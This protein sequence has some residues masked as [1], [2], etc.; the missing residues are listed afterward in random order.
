MMEQNIKT[1]HLYLKEKFK[2]KL[3]LIMTILISAT[4]LISFII[5]IYNF[6][7]ST[8]YKNS[9]EI[10]KA[11]KESL[12]E[13]GLSTELEF[14]EQEWFYYFCNTCSFLTIIV[15]LINSL[16]A[17]GLWFIHFLGMDKIKKPIGF[18]LIRIYILIKIITILIN[19]VL[20]GFVLGICF[21]AG[22]ALAIFLF[23][24][25]IAVFVLLALYYEKLYLLV[26]NVERTYYKNVNYI[27]KSNLIY[28][29][30]IINAVSNLSGLFSL[31]ISSFLS[32]LNISFIIILLVF[33]FKYANEIGNAEKEETI[34]KLKE[35]LKVVKTSEFKNAYLNQN[36]INRFNDGENNIPPME[37]CNLVRKQNYLPDYN[38][39]L[40]IRIEEIALYKR[41]DANYLNIKTTENK[42]V[43][44]III[45]INL[46]NNDGAVE[47]VE[48]NI[49]I[50]LN[51]NNII[52]YFLFIP[53]NIKYVQVKINKIN[54]KNGLSIV[55]EFGLYH[56]DW[57]DQ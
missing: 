19:S 40:P 56:F 48:K 23:I 16:Y 37:E 18:K 45:S 38:K 42:N 36:S 29:F 27:R 30:L 52:D 57:I 55:G 47:F 49:E 43:S 12:A 26:F 22:A 20:L 54:L 2:S 17:V 8:I 31:G 1:P 21:F 41:E 50:F 33:L 5:G 11:I 3:F 7:N 32:A 13:N 51:E 4:F 15:V 35:A 53:N 24:I 44:S 46:D 10:V 25:T 9:V 34:N 28:V 14:I 6:F 39:N